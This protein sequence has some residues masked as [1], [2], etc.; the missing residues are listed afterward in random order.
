MCTVHAYLSANIVL[1]WV[2]FYFTGFFCL[3]FRFV[4]TLHAYLSPNT[5]SLHQNCFI[6]YCSHSVCAEVERRVCMCVCVCM[7]VC[8]CL[9]AQSCMCV[10][11]RVCVIHLPLQQLKL[12]QC[13]HKHPRTHANTHIHT[14]TK[15]LQWSMIDK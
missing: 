1:L 6:Y 8:M 13:T 7:S 15:W 2:L 12:L 9:H 11:E 5:A 4:C 10:R 3:L 14:H